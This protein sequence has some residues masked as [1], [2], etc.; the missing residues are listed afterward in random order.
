M[1]RIGQIS[2]GSIISFKNEPHL[3]VEY[4]HHKPGKG[5][6]VV[7][8]KLKS[9]QSGRMVDNTFR[10]D[11][12]VEVV[13]MGRK[14]VQYL[15]GTNQEYT[16]MD[17]ETYEQFSIGGNVIGDFAPYLKEGLEVVLMVD[18]NGAPVTVDFPKKVTYKV[19]QSPPGVRG[20]TAT[21]VTKEI[22]LENGLKA[23]APL[24]I[25]EG[26]GVVINTETGEYVARA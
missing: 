25:K 20:D 17:M 12:T 10:P 24:F 5:G 3:V 4:Q 8:T 1:A 2:K 22:V 13:E 16:F 6:A 26:D 23:K 14:Q 21:N 15:Y 18:S 19:T 9:L 11:E 7:R